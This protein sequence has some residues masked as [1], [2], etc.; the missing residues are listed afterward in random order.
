MKKVAIITI[1]TICLLFCESAK[2]ETFTHNSQSLSANSKV[3][4]AEAF[5]DNYKYVKVKV[6]AKS[7]SASYTVSLIGTNSISKVNSVD[8]LN[9]S[10]KKFTGTTQYV[11]YILPR[12]GMS[13]PSDASYCFGAGSNYSG[14][15]V[16]QGN[17]CSGSMCS[18][19]GIR[20][21]NKKLL[22]SYN[23]DLSYEFVK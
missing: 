2:A 16:I 4:F 13:C 18:L 23:I 9:T 22:T 19:Y 20:V 6:K 21:N 7:S 15:T 11:I 1:L 17:E 12:S 8:A 5:G 14:T 3:S 10:S